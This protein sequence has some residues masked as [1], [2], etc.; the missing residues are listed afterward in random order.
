MRTTTAVVV[1]R[2]IAAVGGYWRH[3]LNNARRRPITLVWLASNMVARMPH[4]RRMVSA[5]HRT[6]DELITMA[7]IGG[8]AP[9]LSPRSVNNENEQASSPPAASQ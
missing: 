4:R 8:I 3:G 1:N 9:G 6:D 7:V 2:D 5:L